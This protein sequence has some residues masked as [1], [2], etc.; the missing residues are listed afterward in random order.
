[1][2]RRSG[3][4]IVLVGA[5]T[6]IANDTSTTN[7]TSVDTGAGFGRF[8]ALATEFN[9]TINDSLL[10]FKNGEVPVSRTFTLSRIYLLLVQRLCQL[11][12]PFPILSA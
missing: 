5:Y 12:S 3:G 7:G 9:V 1:M 6:P 2:Q 11:K 10:E 8:A 4:E